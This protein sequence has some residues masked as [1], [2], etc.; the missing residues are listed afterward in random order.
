MDQVTAVW[1]P[2][3]LKSNC[4]VPVPSCGFTIATLILTRSLGRLSTMVTFPSPTSLLPDQVIAAPCPASGPSKPILAAGSSLAQGDQASHL[5]KSF[6][7]ANTS[8]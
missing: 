2:S 5:W 1:S 8:A 7:C 4:D 6:T 3:G